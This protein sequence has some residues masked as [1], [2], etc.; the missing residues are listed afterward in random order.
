[1]DPV[2]GRFFDHFRRLHEACKTHFAG[3]DSTALDW[4]PGEGM[5]SIAVLA[6]HTA[7]SEK[8]W[9]GDIVMQDPSGR[10]REAEFTVTGTDVAGLSRLLDSSLATIQ[11]AFERLSLQDLTESRTSP[12]DGVEYDIAWSIAQSLQ[13]TALHLG[14]IQL[15][16]QLL[17]VGRVKS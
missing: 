15:T 3:L 4:S 9:I 8:F 7:G 2:L 6:T 13:H 10:V 5:N 12:L 11:G 17:D 1:M 16:R 14:H